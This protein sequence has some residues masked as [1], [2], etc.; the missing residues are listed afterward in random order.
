MEKSICFT[1][2]RTI[3]KQ[4][5]PEVL[6]ELQRI[7]ETAIS[8]GFVDFYTG[9]AIG[10]DTYCAQ[11]VLDLREDY[12]GIA[13]HLILPCSREE[14]TARWTPEQRAA[15]DCIYEAAD[16]REFIAVDYTKICM[17]QRNQR[18]VELADC[19][20]CYCQEPNGRTGTAQTVR[21]ARQKGIPVINLCMEQETEC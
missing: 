10:W 4:L 19:C 2:H 13:L 1:G 14:Q 7:L 16:S 8:N 6:R 9:G 5:L 17:R 11:L 3:P 21:M 20:I 12:P 15:Y 18:L